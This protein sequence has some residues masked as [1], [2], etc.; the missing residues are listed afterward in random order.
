MLAMST[1]RIHILQTRKPRF[2]PVEQA[3]QVT[4]PAGRGG[5]L[6][7]GCL[8]QSVLV[9]EMQR[10]QTHGGHHGGLAQVA[11]GG[12]SQLRPAT[13]DSSGSGPGLCGTPDLQQGAWALLG[14]RVFVCLTW[15]GLRG[16]QGHPAHHLWT[17]VTEQ[18][19]ADNCD[20]PLRPP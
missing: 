15:W 11:R 5:N 12:W 14:P 13:L 1:V 17:S 19:R 6:N 20:S 18:H 9:F 8:V 2:K 7:S 3:V 10:A 16:P 4:Q